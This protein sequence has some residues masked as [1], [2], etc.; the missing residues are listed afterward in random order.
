MSRVSLELTQECGPH[1]A[2]T[3]PSPRPSRRAGRGGGGVTYREMAMD[4]GCRGEEIDQMAAML[5]YRDRL[6]WECYRDEQEAA[7]AAWIEA[8]E[9]AATHWRREASVGRATEVRT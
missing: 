1:V 5:E 7:E 8:Q 2:P 9:Q 4:A 3:E 6:E